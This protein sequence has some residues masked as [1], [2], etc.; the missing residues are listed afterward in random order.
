MA[1]PAMPEFAFETGAED[2]FRATFMVAGMSHGFERDLR[3]RFMALKFATDDGV[4]A[5][6]M[7]R[8][9]SLRMR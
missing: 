7:G 2:A 3:P 9:S 5:E 4:Y 1:S 6:M 8:M